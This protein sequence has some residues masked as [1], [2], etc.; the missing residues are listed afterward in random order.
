VKL[1][2]VLSRRDKDLNREY[3]RYDITLP[4]DVIDELGWQNIKELDY[5]IKG[6]EL[7]IKKK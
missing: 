5:E 2:K 1:K 7:R 4:N 6:K 3:Y